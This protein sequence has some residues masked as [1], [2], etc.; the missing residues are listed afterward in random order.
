MKEQSITHTP[1]ISVQDVRLLDVF[2]VAPFCFYTATFKSLP[3]WVRAGLVIL[4]TSTLLYN[5][6]NYLLNRKNGI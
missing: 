1:L 2:V 6:R 4:G 5:G 3:T